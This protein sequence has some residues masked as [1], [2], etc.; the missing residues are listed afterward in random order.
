MRQP[1][2]VGGAFDAAFFT[3][4][5]F[6]FAARVFDAAGAGA[7]STPNSAVRSSLVIMTRSRAAALGDRE[8]GARRCPD[9]C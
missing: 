2:Q 8:I 5:T 3:G 1:D 7:I 9:W 4:C 6:F